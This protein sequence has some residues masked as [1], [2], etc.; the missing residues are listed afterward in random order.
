[1][2]RLL[3]IEY[4]QIILININDVLR[5]ASTFT[6]LNKALPVFDWCLLNGANKILNLMTTKLLFI[7]RIIQNVLKTRISFDF[8]LA[9]F[10][11]KLNKLLMKISV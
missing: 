9:L 2:I 7:D 1:M 8:F 4:M 11:N 3:G 5:L 6:E 10:K